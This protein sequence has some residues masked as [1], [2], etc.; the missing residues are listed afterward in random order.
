MDPSFK[1]DM[2]NLLKKTSIFGS[3]PKAPPLKGNKKD[4]IGH[5]MQ[6]NAVLSAVCADPTM[7]LLEIGVYDEAKEWTLLQM[8]LEALLGTDGS[9]IRVYERDRN[10]AYALSVSNAAAV[11]T[12]IMKEEFKI[13]HANS[14]VNTRR[15]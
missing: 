11:I 5:T 10:I 15:H 13:A 14:V 4:N 12:P 6:E 9:I 8:K 7:K 3:K 2:K 1:L